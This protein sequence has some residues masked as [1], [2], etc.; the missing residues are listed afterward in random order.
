MTTAYPPAGA[1]APN[2]LAARQVRYGQLL[3][4]S[5]DDESGIGGGWQIKDQSGGLTAVER[6]LLTARVVTKFDVDPALPQFPTAEQIAARPARLAYSPTD[7]GA[8]LWHTVDAG[9]DATGR[10]GNVMAHIVLDRDT[11]APSRLRPI[12]LWGS[13][14]WCRPYGAADVLSTEL[15]KQVPAPNPEFT[16][17][18]VIHFLAGTAVDRQG[19]FRVLLDAV[20]AAMT[21][22]PKVALLTADNTTGPLW[23]AAVSFFMSPG[24]ARRF[25]WTTH[26]RP[27][28]A[29][30]NMRKGTHL[31]VVPRETAT[32]LPVVGEWVVLD[33]LEEPTVRELGSEHIA[34]AAKITVTA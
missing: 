12:Q 6:E 18:A 22:G 25:S 8:A 11:G 31:V 30:T 4:T 14:D 26:D 29:V 9:N 5:F 24:C 23:I 1:P 21:G 34:G 28:Q 2:P 15:G 3:Y 10:P 17:A 27:A 19:T 20:Y 33:E 7:V 32:A 13:P 16:A